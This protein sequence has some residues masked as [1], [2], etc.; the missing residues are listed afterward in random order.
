MPSEF[1][2]FALVTIAI[3][4]LNIFKDFGFGAALIQKQNLEKSEIDSIF[5][6]NNGIGFLLGT[7]IFFSAPLIGAF[8]EEPK[9][10]LL[11]QAMSVI[12]FIGSFGL[13]PDALIAKNIDFKSFFFRN[14]ANNV[15]SGAIAVFMAYKGYGVWALVFQSLFSTIIGVFI[16][17]KMVQWRPSF[18]F[19][20]E[21]SVPF[22]K[23]SMPL[24]GE[25]SINYWVRNI[26]NILVGKIL[27]EQ[28]LGYY[29]KA[30]SLMLLPVR[31]IS[32]SITRVM[33]PSFSLIKNDKQ[34]VWHNYS[35]LLSI[36]AFITF[37]LMAVLYIFGGEIILFMY[38][39]DWV[40]SISI[41]KGL[42]FLGA[43]QSLG[44]YCGSIFSSQGRTYLQFKLGLFLK[45]LM[46]S[47][48][49]FGLYWNGIDGLI[50]GYTLTSCIAFG[51][52]S[53]F[54]TK[55]LDQKPIEMLKSFY[56]EFLITSVLMIGF[57]IV[58]KY[59]AL[60]II[61][62]MLTILLIGGSLYFFLSMKLKVRGVLF[63]KQKYDGFKKNN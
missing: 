40:E 5:W 21:S 47:G 34:K 45:P 6:L 16:S 56:K 20:K 26:D 19:S 43:I 35:E 33:F 46:I 36:T 18:Q 8:Y 7:I 3:G 42:C 25:N 37:P 2:L 49:V 55:I 48:I 38:G 29:S 30:Y 24:L 23:F 32:G 62:K 54:I 4:F 51:I 17:F 39:K 59:F 27:G 52:E 15:I 60:H 28:S 12:F 63:V 61:L 22:L 9:L 11:T 58:E 13:V 31:Q 10:I 50:I 53:F 41:F 14:I 44:V 1:G 57:L